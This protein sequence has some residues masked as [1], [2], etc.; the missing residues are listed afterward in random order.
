M[1]SLGGTVGHIVTSSRN[2]EDA[3]EKVTMGKG[4]LKD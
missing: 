1:G 2:V 3:T 4:P